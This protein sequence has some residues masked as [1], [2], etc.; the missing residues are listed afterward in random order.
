MEKPIGVLVAGRWAIVAWCSLALM[1]ASCGATDE[2]R[3][4]NPAVLFTHSCIDLVCEF[5]GYSSVDSAGQIAEWHWSLGDG[6]SSTSQ[7]PSHVYP[8]AGTFEVT[9]TVTGSSGAR[10][11]RE[12]QLM[13]TESQPAD[14]PPPLVELAFGASEAGRY[15]TNWTHLEPG[16]SLTIDDGWWV[17]D[18]VTAVDLGP[19]TD[20]GRRTCDPLVTI[21]V[22]QGIYDPVE[23]RMVP[24]DDL[25]ETLL[26]D[27][28]FDVTAVSL[29]E[30][31]GYHATRIDGTL[32]PD[33]VEPGW[34]FCG[35]GIRMFAIGASNLNDPAHRW[36]WLPASSNLSFWVVRVE[37]SDVLIA[38]SHE[39]PGSRLLGEM[40]EV[41]GSL[42]FQPRREPVPTRTL[43]SKFGDIHIRNGTPR[44]HS[45]VD[46]SVGRFV[47]SGMGSPGVSTVTFSADVACHE[48]GYAGGF[49]EVSGL[50]SQV[51]LCFGEER[52]GS[53]ARPTLLHEFAH[54][55]FAIHLGEE[56]RA[57]FLTLFGLETW[58]PSRPG[59]PQ[60]GVEYASDVIAWGLLDRPDVPARLSDRSCET[61]LV[62]FRLLTGAEPLTESG[63]CDP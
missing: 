38:A 14:L 41:I 17:T 47:E 63:G 60:A 8:H 55:W 12:V 52:P 46:W 36:V 13:L 22:L 39:E 11:R 51:S 6:T 57:R 53:L 35:Y 5:D 9:L 2:G 49:T 61:L 20:W 40:E 33:R 44:L 50:G 27:A 45:L 28:R 34:R 15:V 32:N 26:D 21:V 59:P 16:L 54:A 42:E 37:A 10:V 23:Q 3:D 1:T 48:Q 62:A 7:N 19:L 30:V 56:T 25:A 18:T 4:A 58:Y 43:H 29:T 24:F 31:G